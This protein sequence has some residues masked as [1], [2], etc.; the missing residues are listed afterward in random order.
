MSGTKCKKNEWVPAV[1]GI[2]N[3]T[4]PSPL[5][6]AIAPANPPACAAVLDQS[7]VNGFATVSQ[8]ASYVP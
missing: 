5:F 1:F 3:V 8:Y 7:A 2:A 4:V 6:N